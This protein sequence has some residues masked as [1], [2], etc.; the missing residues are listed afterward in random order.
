MSGLWGAAPVRL[1]CGRGRAVGAGSSPSGADAPPP[2]T[3][4]GEKA[5]GI[6]KAGKCG[7]LD[8][9]KGAR[10]GQAVVKRF[11]ALLGMTDGLSLWRVGEV[12][13]IWKAVSGYRVAALVGMADG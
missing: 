6:A 2:S 5:G 7:A 13:L 9:R 12:W 3:E 4:G 10:Q 8:L 1:W 11:L